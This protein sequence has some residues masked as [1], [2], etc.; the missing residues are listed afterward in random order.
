VLQRTELQLVIP[1]AGAGVVGLGGDQVAAGD[2]LVA[3]DGRVVVDGPLVFFE[4][5]GGVV[6]TNRKTPYPR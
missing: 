1:L 2:Q 3:L 4:N 6:D 5:L